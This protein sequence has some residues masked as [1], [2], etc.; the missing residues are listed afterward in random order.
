MQS[1]TIWLT[2]NCNL[3]CRYCYEGQEKG[4]RKFAIS[5][6]T[7][8]ISFIEREI[9]ESAKKEDSGTVFNRFNYKKVVHF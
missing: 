6:I 5:N 7:A 8:L 4:K 2:E 1:A 3:K 9:L